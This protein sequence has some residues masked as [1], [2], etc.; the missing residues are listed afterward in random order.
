MAGW[1][2]PALKAVLPHLGSIVSAA[3]PVFSESGTAKQIEELQSAVAQNTAD[4]KALAG[5]LETAIKAL[6][7]AAARMRWLCFASLGV[8]LL[9]LAASVVAL[10]R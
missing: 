5:E 3:R 1:L 4:L 10:V 6:D 9:A 2:V 8:S 7:G